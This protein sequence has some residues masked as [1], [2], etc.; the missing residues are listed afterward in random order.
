MY[1]WVYKLQYIHVNKMEYKNYVIIIRIPIQ[2][3]QHPFVR[4]TSIHTVTASQL[5]QFVLFVYLASLKPYY[6]LKTF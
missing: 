4:M 1:Q 2:N 6:V 3:K 5:T